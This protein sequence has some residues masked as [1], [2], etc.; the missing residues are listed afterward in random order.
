M[1]LQHRS[2]GN[3]YIGIK[4][5]TCY[6][7]PMYGFLTELCCNTIGYSYIPETCFTTFYCLDP[8]FLLK[9]ILFN[10]LVTTCTIITLTNDGKDNNIRSSTCSALN[11]V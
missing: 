7:M 2:V 6:V 4:L 10:I 9:L 3:P 5:N 8:Y 1:V 11:Q